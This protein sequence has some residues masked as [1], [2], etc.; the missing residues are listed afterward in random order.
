LDL[1]QQAGDR[2]PLIAICAKVQGAPQMKHGAARFAQAMQRDG[3]QDPGRRQLWFQCLPALGSSERLVEMSQLHMSSSRD[4]GAVKG[5]SC[6]K[7]LC[8]FQSQLKL[9]G[10][11][12]NAHGGQIGQNGGGQHTTDCRKSGHDAE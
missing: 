3:P 2:D 10:L 7:I 5:V 8:L 9:T 11:K 6:G 1:S 4:H 12:G